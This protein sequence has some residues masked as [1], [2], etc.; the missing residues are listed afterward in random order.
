ML[1]QRMVTVLLVKVASHP[2]SQNWPIEI[3]A[4]FWRSGKMCAWQVARGKVGRL[5]KAVWVEWIVVPLGKRTGMPCGVG[6]LWM[7]GLF[8]RRKWP[9][10]PELASAVFW[11]KGE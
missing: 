9:V 3:R 8:T 7:Q 10:Q 11:D 5:S 2:W 4:L 6:T 1:S